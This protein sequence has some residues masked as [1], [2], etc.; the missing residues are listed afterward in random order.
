MRVISV[1]YAMY[2]N[3]RH[4]RVGSLF[5]GRFQAKLIE[6]DEYLLQLSKYI[7]RNAKE[8]TPATQNLLSY[9]YSSY[10]NYVTSQKDMMID[11]STI[12]S[13]FSQKNPQISYQNF[14]EEHEVDKE[15]L[16]NFLFEE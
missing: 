5:Q 16:S 3:Q 4:H 15:N 11:S 9:P 14:V 7:H 13:Y 1:A 12:L 6:K 8:I 10:I 2:F